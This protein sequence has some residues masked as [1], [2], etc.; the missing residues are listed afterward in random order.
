MRPALYG[1]PTMDVVDAL[2]SGEISIVI[3][4]CALPWAPV[5]HGCLDCDR[6]LVETAGGGLITEDE[7]VESGGPSHLGAD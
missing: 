1:M 2:E 3:G 4:G 5:R 6:M 7:W